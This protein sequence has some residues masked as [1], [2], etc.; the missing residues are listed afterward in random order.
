M[1]VR[2]HQSAKGTLAQSNV[3]AIEIAGPG[4][5]LAARIGERAED[6]SQYRHRFVSEDRLRLEGSRP[7]CRDA[8]DTSALLLKEKAALSNFIFRLYSVVRFHAYLIPI[9]VGIP[10]FALRFARAFH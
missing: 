5:R 4:R 10:R 6:R 3:E 7:R 8:W 2:E 9:V 1:R